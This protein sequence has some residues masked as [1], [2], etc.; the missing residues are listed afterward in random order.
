MAPIWKFAKPITELQ[1]IV[2]RS[3]LMYPH[4]AALARL[5]LPTLAAGSDVSV[6]IKHEMQFVL[7]FIINRYFPAYITPIK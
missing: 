1:V 7:C 4:T 2:R 6:V 3:V 5:V